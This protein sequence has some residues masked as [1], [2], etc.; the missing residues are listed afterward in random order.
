VFSQAGEKMSNQPYT[1]SIEAITPK[2]VKYREL[3]PIKYVVK[4]IGNTTFPGGMII[5]QI[6]FA[7]ISS[8]VTQVIDIN[9]SIAAG[10]E[11]TNKQEQTALSIGYVS[12]TV[13][14]VASR[15]TTQPR[16]IEIYLPDGRRLYPPQMQTAAQL[17]HAV[18]AVSQEEISEKRGVWIAAISLLILI[19]FQILDWIFQY[20]L[21][22]GHA[23]Q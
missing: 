2:E 14:A 21:M 1:L 10:G 3:I 12:F 17:F 23:T 19:G 7:G 4:N 13:V 18:P 5:V 15:G 16:N 8:V 22:A 6:N 20:V 11:F 9:Q